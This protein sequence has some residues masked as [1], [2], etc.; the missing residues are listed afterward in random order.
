[1]TSARRTRAAA[2]L[3]VAANLVLVVVK[4]A[5][6][7][8]SGSVAVL[9]E[10][11]HSGSDLVASLVGLGAV[12]AAAK[13]ADRGHPYGHERAENLAA[14][15][16]GILILGVGGF[17]AA[18]AIRRLVEGGSVSHLG[19]AMGVMA[20]SAL[21]SLVVALR[22]RRV[23]RE[24]GSPALGGVAT[25]FLAD[26]VTSAGILIGLT[27]VAI[28]G[29][30]RLDPIVALAV[31]AWILF[32]GGR[33]VWRSA[34]VLLDSAL[35]EDEIAVLERVLATEAGGGV[36]FHRLR[37]RRAG[38]KRHVDLHMVVPPETTVREG[39]ARAGAVK[40]ALVDALPNTEVLIHL[41]DADPS[42]SIPALSP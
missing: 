31:A 11:A 38:A 32:V 7:V 30:E 34:H 26:V 42:P 18:E 24:T 19:L 22:V 15:T 2:L 20:G 1:M 4:L 37:G 17:V 39:H 10:A 9:S 12:R 35:P 23:A 14:A 33:L 16:E 13:P 5:V 29:W 28:T 3:S 21:V 36:S 40:A 6:G 27:L 8:V 41:E 25:D